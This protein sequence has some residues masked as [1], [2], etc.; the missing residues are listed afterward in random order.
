MIY[1]TTTIKHHI[2]DFNLED[3]LLVQER[4]MLGN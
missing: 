4:V 3:K 2:P 1:L